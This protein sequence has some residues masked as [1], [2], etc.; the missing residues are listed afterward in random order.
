SRHQASRL[1]D[2][3]AVLLGEPLEIIGGQEVQNG[4]GRSAQADAERTDDDRA[5][6]QDR[7]GLDRIEQLIVC[8]ARVPEAQ[9]G[10]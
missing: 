6:E 7:M 5:I 9:V 4:L 8:Q 10:E 2:D 1:D 3:L